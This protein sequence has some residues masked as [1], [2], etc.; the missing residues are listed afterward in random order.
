MALPTA[1]LA[2][3]ALALS[4]LARQEPALEPMVRAVL[5]AGA[6]AP[7]EGTALELER[8]APPALPVFLD[9]LSREATSSAPPLDPAAERALLLALAAHIDACR[10]LLAVRARASQTARRAVLGVLEIGGGAQDLRLAA[11]AAQAEREGAEPDPVALALL[12][13]AARAIVLREGK[14]GCDALRAVYDEAGLE[15]KLRWIRALGDVGSQPALELLGSWVGRPDEPSL[16]LVQEISRAAARL[17]PPFDASLRAAVRTCLSD[18]S[19]ALR[20]E[21]ALAVGRLGDDESLPLLVALLE[22][23]SGPRRNAWWALKAITGRSFR[24]DARPWSRWVAAEQ[25]W[26]RDRSGTVLAEL[27]SADEAVVAAA[28]QEIAAHRYRRHE[29]ALELSAIAGEG[30]ADRARLVCSALVQLGSP[31]ARKGLEACLEHED[32]GVRQRAAA[33]LRSMGGTGGR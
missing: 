21:A 18:G 3:G 16:V 6:G 29:L 14:R 5:E 30:S 20:R 9:L 22:G 23:E 8:F 10:P 15:L 12:E 7:S 2:L 31:L 4:A 1:C 11:A 26:W 28:V 32:A 33:A 27:R 19:P 25:A 13:R 24:E 17:E